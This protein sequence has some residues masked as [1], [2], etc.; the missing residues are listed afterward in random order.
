MANTLNSIGTDTSEL[1]ASPATRAL[2]EDELTTQGSDAS[3][4]KPPNEASGQL[5]GRPIYSDQDTQTRSPSAIIQPTAPHLAP[6][7]RDDAI[8][9]PAR[10]RAETAA[11]IAHWINEAHARETRTPIERLT[12]TQVEQFLGTGETRFDQLLSI[13]EQ[14]GYVFRSDRFA[15]DIEQYTRELGSTNLEAMHFY[16][17]TNPSREHPARRLLE[18]IDTVRSQLTDSQAEYRR[19]VGGALGNMVNEMSAIK[20]QLELRE[21][22]IR[23]FRSDLADCHQHGED[24]TK[25][26]TELESTIHEL[27]DRLCSSDSEPSSPGSTPKID[28]SELDQ[29]RIELAAL[30]VE[31]ALSQEAYKRHIDMLRTAKERIDELEAQAAQ[32]MAENAELRSALPSTDA[33]ASAPNPPLLNVPPM[34]PKAG[35]Q[36]DARSTLVLPSPRSPDAGSHQFAPAT[37]SFGPAEPAHWKEREA[38]IANSEAYKRTREMLRK[39]REAEESEQNAMWDLR[40]EKYKRLCGRE[41]VPYVSMEDRLKDLREQTA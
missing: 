36:V 29:F 30:K 22:E 19:G 1:S 35:P 34:T 20:S 8:R 6:L 41:E 38:T 31:Q 11:H 28:Q 39:K 2:A 13:L 4:A 7:L 3:T 24:L 40:Q 5:V 27:T 18:E 23:R 9:W 26:K 12:A 33:P 21:H 10:F 37:P 16:R 14:A 32:T 17:R 25:Q 15:Q